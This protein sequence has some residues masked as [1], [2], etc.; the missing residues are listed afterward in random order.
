MN[1]R[2]V[3]DNYRNEWKYICS[4]EDWYYLENRLKKLLRR[5]S[6]ASENGSYKVHSLYF[7]DIRDSCKADNDAGNAHRFKFRIRYYGDS[8]AFLRLECKKKINSRCRKL[9]GVITEE[10]YQML[11]AGRSDELLSET[12]DPLLKKFCLYFSQR[13]LTPR[14]IIDYDRTAYIEEV[15]NIRITYDTNIRVSE[16]TE[17][18][19]TGDYLS[20]AFSRGASVLEVKFDSIL[21]GYL[22]RLINEKNPEVTAFSKYCLGRQKF[23]VLPT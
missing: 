21:P 17:S 10:Q 14:I 15:T 11:A 13:L 8:P 16:E 12:E 20:R 23:P 6:H 4:N 1:N 9:T 22:S 3:S 2:A 19:L 7:D 18:F 5:D